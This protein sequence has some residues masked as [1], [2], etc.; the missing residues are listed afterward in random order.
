MAGTSC[1]LIKRCVFAEGLRFRYA[2]NVTP[3][4]LSMFDV[5]RA[6]FVCK[7]HGDVECGHLP[8]FPLS[9]KEG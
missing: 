3:D 7:V 8:E 4:I 1:I 9:G 5:Q 2:P 6:A